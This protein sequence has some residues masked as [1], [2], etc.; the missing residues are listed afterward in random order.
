MTNDKKN[1]ILGWIK[2]V[3]AIVDWLGTAWVSFPSKENYVG[4]KY[5]EVKG[6]DK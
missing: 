2:Y 3:A 5:N 6:P 4:K 1:E